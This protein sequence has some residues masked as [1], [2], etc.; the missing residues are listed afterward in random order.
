MRQRFNFNFFHIDSPASLGTFLFKAIFFNVY[1]F[2]REWARE[3]RERGRQRIWR[4]LWAISTKPDEGLEPTNHKIMTWAKVY[5]QPTEP[6]RCPIWFMICQIHPY[7]YRSVPGIPL[8]N[9]YYLFYNH[10]CNNGFRQES[11]LDARTIWWKVVEKEDKQMAS[12]YLYRFPIN[13]IGDVPP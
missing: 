2:L 5:T 13:S 8:S 6:P 1:W 10:Q 7:P 4:R 11:K 9:L 12:K 3:G